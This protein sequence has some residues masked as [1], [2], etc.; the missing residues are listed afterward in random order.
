MAWGVLQY[1]Q[2]YDELY[3]TA[4]DNNSGAQ[5]GGSLITGVSQYGQPAN[6]DLRLGRWRMAILP[7]TK[8]SQIYA[9]P[10]SHSNEANSRYNN[11]GG[12]TVDLPSIFNYGVNFY[13]VA[14]GGGTAGAPRALAEFQQPTMIPMIADSGPLVFNFDFWRVVNSNH[15]AQANGFV[16]TTLNVV[17]EDAA[18]HLNG[19][20]LL[21]CDG[22]VKFYPQARLDLDPARTS[23]QVPD[24]WKLPLRASDNRVQ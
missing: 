5:F 16:P 15:Q 3:P 10:S 2:D 24:R 4:D 19:S 18:R 12:G 22:H 9:D 21:F 14:S 13:V 6:F 8:S 17:S 23:L 7:Y 20:N 11:P 1:T